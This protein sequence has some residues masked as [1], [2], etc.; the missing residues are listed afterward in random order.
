MQIEQLQK[1]MIAAMKAKDKPRKD[2]ISSLVSA[3]KKT[4]IDEAVVMT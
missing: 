1:E 3:V 2:A 4:A